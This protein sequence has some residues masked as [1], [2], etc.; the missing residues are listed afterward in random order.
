VFVNQEIVLMARERTLAEA[1]HVQYQRDL[2]D[3]AEVTLPVWRRRGWRERR[4]E[5]LGWTARRLL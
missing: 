4:L 2:G 5:A 3:A 1:L